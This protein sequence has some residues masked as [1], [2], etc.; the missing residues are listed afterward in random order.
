MTKKRKD[1]YLGI[2]TKIDSI[3]TRIIEIKD[4]LASLK[5]GYLDTHNE[6]GGIDEAEAEQAY[7]GGTSEQRLAAAQ[8]RAARSTAQRQAAYGEAQTRADVAGAQRFGRVTEAEQLYGEQGAEAR[9]LSQ[10]LSEA[11][12][13]RTYG[14]DVLGQQLT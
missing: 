5:K 1:C 3:E 11:G 10:L 7:A 9:R 8:A 12:L 2:F 4:Q 13:Q 14:Q 6:D